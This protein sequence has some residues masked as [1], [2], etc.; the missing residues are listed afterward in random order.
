[1]KFS[2]AA[3]ELMVNLQFEV[4]IDGRQ[5]SNNALPRLAHAVGVALIR[6]LMIEAELARGVLVAVASREYRSDRSY[7]L[8][9][10]A[11]MSEGRTLTAFRCWIETEAASYRQAT[12]LV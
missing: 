10:P 4:K 12:G 9:N 11:Q 7:Y 6:H 2:S 8:I 5:G 1:M 3:L